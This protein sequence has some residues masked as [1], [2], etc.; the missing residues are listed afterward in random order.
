MECDG[1]P[2]GPVQDTWLH[3]FDTPGVY[4]VLCSPHETFGMA[5]RIVV[6]DGTETEFETSNPEA[7]P[8]P[9]AGPVGLARITLTDPAL[10][11]SNVAE[12]GTVE[13]QELAANEPETG[14]E[15]EGAEPTGTPP[16][17]SGESTETPL[18]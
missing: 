2:E 10:Q 16:V 17:T 6:G 12:Q 3:A 13:W 15:T 8:E 1:E 14:T 4:D 11:P 18:E 5:M 7:L 9:R